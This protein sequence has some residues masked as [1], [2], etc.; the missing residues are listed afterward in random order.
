MPNESVKI[1]SK[2]DWNEAGTLYPPTNRSFNVPALLLYG[3]ASVL[4]CSARAQ[5]AADAP[6][7]A[8][9]QQGPPGAEAPG[10][11]GR[12]L[13]RNGAFQEGTIGWE[14]YSWGKNGKMEID[15]L[16]RY[17]GKPALRVD[18]LEFCH[19]FVRQVL[20]GKANTRYLLTGYIK[21]KDV[22]VEKGKKSGAVL[23]VGR[24]GLY[25][26]L[27]EG[28]KPWTKVTVDFTTKDDA[29]IRVGPSLGT[30]PVFV[31]GTAWFSDL[32]L[33][34]LGRPAGE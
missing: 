11:R 6:A 23:E 2:F 3:L 24:T 13:L 28:T 9:G 25:T 10:S 19:S 17:E 30:D 26:P 18:N 20:V 15:P 8:P 14:I 4:L 16:E 7:F 22:A 33:I 21:T 31:K 27:M 34:E 5:V 12:N 32:R 1:V 29:T